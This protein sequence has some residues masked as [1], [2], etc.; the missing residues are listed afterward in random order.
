MAQFAVF[1]VQ[2]VPPVGTTQHAQVYRGDHADE[3]TAVAAAAAALGLSQN[4][5]VWAC[6][7]GSLT[8]YHIDVTKSYNT[9]LG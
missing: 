5:K 2:D 8:A 3:S 4:V 9:V 1:L 7:I 6:A